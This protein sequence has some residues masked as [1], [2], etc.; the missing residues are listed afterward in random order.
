MSTTPLDQLFRERILVLDGAMGSL[1]QGYG[2]TEADY[3]HGYFEDHP[4]DLKGNHDLLVLTRP[5]VIREIHEAYLEAGA[6]VIETN[7]FSGTSIAQEDYGTEHIVY[8][9]NVAAARVARE[10]ADKFTAR[11]PTKPRFVAGAVGPTNRTLSI[12]PD[13]NDPG[14]RAITFP[15][16][17]DAYATQIR[18][19][20]DGGADL[21]LIETIFDTLNAKA[22]LFA[23][24]RVRQALGRALPV[25]ISGTITD[26]SGR[27]LS[28]QTVEAFYISVAH[29]K[30]LCV[31]LNCALGAQ[32]MRTHLAALS[33]IAECNVHAYPNAGLPNELGAYDQGAEEMQGY[34]RDFAASGFVNLIGGCCGTTPE[35]IRQM[36]L[37]VA[38]LPPRQIPTLPPYAQYSGLEP[39]IVRP[40]T[41]F[42]N[43]GERTNVTGSRKFSRLIM[44]GKYSEALDVARD[45]VEGGAQVIDVNMDEG[46][47]NSKE[48]M[49]T[50]LNLMMAEPDIARL[51]VMIDSSKWDVIEAGLQCVQGKCIVNS[52]SMKEGEAEFLRQARLVKAYGAAAVVMAFDEEGQ[53]DTADRKVEICHRAYRLLTEEIGFPPQDIIFDPNI[54]AVATGIEE[55]NNYGVDFI[56]AT[57]RIK[58]LCPGVKISG[59]VSNV[60][61]SFRGNDVVREAMHSAFL[62]HAIR[63][64]M[65]MGIV[66]A[67]MI[68][69]YQDIPSQLLTHV[70]DVILN[71]RPDATERLTELAESLKNVGGR[72]VVKD[73]AW[74]E[75]TVEERL[76]HSLV[77][78]ITEFIVEDTEEARL[79]YPRPLHVIEGP[80][81]DGMNVVGDLFGSGKMFLPQV[82]KSAR[83]MKQAVAYLQPFIEQE[84]ADVLA[85][86]SQR[87]SPEKGDQPRLLSN[88][89]ESVPATDESLSPGPSPKERGDLTSVH[90]SDEE[91]IP[92]VSE[93][94]WDIPDKHFQAILGYAKKLRRNQTTAEKM[95]WQHLQSQKTGHKIV[96]QKPMG[97]SVPDFVCI[98]KKVIIEVDGGYH[99]TP[100]MIWSDEVRSAKF[101]SVGYEVLRFTNEA[102]LND[103]FT[104]SA[105][106]KSTLDARKDREYPYPTEVYY[107][108]NQDRSLLDGS[109]LSFGEGP[110]E[111]EM[112]LAD[113]PSNQGIKL[114]DTTLLTPVA[115]VAEKDIL[116]R[117]YKGTILLATVKG[118]VHDIGKNIVG[119]VLACNNYR[120]IDLGVMVPANKILDEAQKHKVDIIGL[121]GLIT[122]S[123]DEM[124]NVAAEMERRG[125]TTPL[126][127]GGA[128]TSKTHTALK[129]EPA[130]RGGPT[131]HVLDASRAVT[132]AGKL[133][134]GE[135]ADREAYRQ[136]ITAEYDRV[137]VHRARQ[138]SGKQN[139][140]ISQARENHLVLDWDNYTP[141]VPTF[142]GTR[143]FANYDLGEL[144]DY[145]DWTPFFSSWGL[146]GKFPDILTDE[147]VGVEASN[148]YAEAR[149]ML[150][151]VVA[152]K[153]LGAKAVIGF[154]PAESDVHTDTIHVQTPEGKTY[155]LLQ[156]R[157]QSKKAA[158]QPN[159]ALTDFIAPAAA[160]NGT[161]RQDYLGAFAVSTGFGIEA[162][163]ARFEADGDDYSA[164]ML[165]ALADRLAEAFAER[166]H[167]RVRRE[168]W[169]YAPDE[170]ISNE[171]LIA[172]E[173]Q[174][175]RPAPGYPACPEHTEKS[176]LWE[177]LDVERNTGMELT[178]SMAMHPASSVSGW[179]YS[180]P[181]AK[182]FTV[183]G[184]QDD[185]AA[186][187]AA[188]KGWDE[189][190]AEQWLGPIR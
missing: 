161:A 10:A 181:A 99:N 90:S 16:L 160:P 8:E 119:V 158:G 111:R 180:H 35:H 165:K 95:L 1:I 20:A 116:A 155:P 46:L 54:F 21:I 106:I 187:Y 175:I 125:M 133:L 113:R 42:I 167:Q 137:R 50:F 129:V 32:E 142:T 31:G 112:A 12:S 88:N 85:A 103:P 115:E 152:E 23:L 80:L 53:A 151:K 41:N 162:H 5:D 91:S 25:M 136:S 64:G 127:I 98:Q 153:W 40:E 97:Y 182:Y 26:A 30:P 101:R 44:D 172:E 34:I 38:G 145:I 52:I 131:V 178:E 189:A 157:Q 132:V 156:L 77:R 39:L 110:G 84:K 128:T 24:E 58:T 120:I 11:N 36:A 15:Q 2:L 146:A 163:V 51:P 176:K 135:A 60:S 69:V 169:G 171:Q 139:L 141:P 7:T 108:S 93:N 75:S 144:V 70:E 140:S 166:M 89:Q 67:G 18:G 170:A 66:N 61:F 100:E 3:R 122:P 43:V 71:R 57:Q 22:A 76:R 74:R 87:S 186:E 37:A 188:R 109:P 79:K 96:R 49:V 118:D 105:K 47:L 121:S 13:V 143:V 9:L 183:R 138:Q 48:A 28:G 55:H 6:D 68:E 173:Y 177:L 150:E 83:V 17:A 124:V 174:G 81:M 159:L 62:Y 33:K 134:D 107:P 164:I 184:I 29:A 123:L 59:G 117:Q 19:L 65:D 86:I 179:Y 27:T 168:F 154:F 73:L 149:E 82:V 190:T 78:G 45:Q 104:V 114:P 14:Y 94:Y 102:I 72:S 63:A 56:E 148:L 126:L 147:V 92:V 4:K 185:Q 130:Y